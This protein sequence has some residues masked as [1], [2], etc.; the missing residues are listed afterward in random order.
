PQN[1]VL[2]DLGGVK[3]AVNPEE[4]LLLALLP[5]EATPFLR[6]RRAEEHAAKADAIAADK[7][8]AEAARK[9]KCANITGEVFAAPMG[10]KIISVNVKP[11]DKVK[12]GEIMFVY[13]AMKMEN[14]VEAEK[15]L[16][17]KQ[18][19]AVPGEIV[20]TDEP[21]IEFE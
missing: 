9:A 8:A 14:D 16:T 10:G 17:V 15:D 3:L 2:E 5:N 18:I 1:P 7:A 21:I 4:E 11:G 6:R 13:E 19:F 20:Y 12:K